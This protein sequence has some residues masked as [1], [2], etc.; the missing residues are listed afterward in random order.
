MQMRKV[1][2]RMRLLLCE[3]NSTAADNGVI[4]VGTL[5]LVRCYLLNSSACDTICCS[6]T[7][8]SLSLSPIVSSFFLFFLPIASTL[9]GKPICSYICTCASGTLCPELCFSFL[10]C[11]L[12][13]GN[14]T[15]R[16]NWALHR[17][18]VQFVYGQ[19]DQLGIA[20]TLKE[21]LLFNKGV[22]HFV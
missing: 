8:P 20:L 17:N 21:T 11:L 13:L 7:L 3:M 9:C 4:E 1:P 2:L 12:I 10:L 15:N 14:T 22:S 5:W 18:R 6:C 19:F 16:V